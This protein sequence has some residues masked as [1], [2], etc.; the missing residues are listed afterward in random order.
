M[1]VGRDSFGSI[2]SLV[3]IGL[4]EFG[5]LQLNSGSLYDTRTI[6]MSDV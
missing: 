1:E 5:W 3:V 6:G 2:G 4:S